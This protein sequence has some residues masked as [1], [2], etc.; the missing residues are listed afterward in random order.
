[1]KAPWALLPKLRAEWCLPGAQEQG[2]GVP[3]RRKAWEVGGSCEKP[4][5]ESVM[6]SVSLLK[7]GPGRCRCFPRCH[8]QGPGPRTSGCGEL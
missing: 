8:S 7:L 3:S 1:M 4:L 5:P 2:R 6:G